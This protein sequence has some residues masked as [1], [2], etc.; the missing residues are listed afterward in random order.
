MQYGLDERPP[1]GAFLLY[2]LQWYAVSLPATIIIGMVA[3]KLYAPASPALQMWYM[4]KLFV[5]MGLTMALQALMGHKLPGVEGPASILFVGV[6]TC[7]SVG[8]PAAYTA[9]MIGGAVLALGAG[10]GLFDKIRPIF[11]PR[12]VATILVLVAFT[13]APTIRRL[14]FPVDGREIF[15]LFFGITLVICMVAVNQA[16]KGVWKAMTVL[17]GLAGGSII[18][19]A[20]F[21]MPAVA[22]AQENVVRPFF[23]ER[24]DF[25][26]GVILSFLVCFLAVGVNQVG[27]LESVGRIV[28]ADQMAGRIKRGQILEGIFSTIAGGLGVL[29]PVSLSLSAG[30][31]S[32]TGCAARLPLVP[33]GIGLILCGLIPGAV[34]FFSQIPGPVMGAMLMYLMA[35]QLTGGLIMLSKEKSAEDF[36]GGI[37]VG[38]AMMVGLSVAFLPENASGAVPPIL[39]P[40][41]CNGFIMGVLVISILEHIVFRKKA[42]P[43]K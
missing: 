20:I 3:A 42:E 24:F 28:G 33:A 25:Q 18:Y 29:G 14:L 41:L 2:G 40:L 37:R 13:M 7:Q 27:T 39:R 6:I 19:L 10:L 38:V 30:I 8:M 16:L 43:A 32:A 4:Q 15:H 26:P 23:L 17:L 12:I 1:A 35:T 36:G 5:I 21:G 9:I 11:T 22:V 34:N 31:V